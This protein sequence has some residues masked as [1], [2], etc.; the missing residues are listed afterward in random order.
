MTKRRVIGIV[1]AAFFSFAASSIWYSPMLFGKQ[2]IALSGADT[3][4]APAGLKIAAEVLRNLLLAFVI[5]GLL[6]RRRTVK[7]SELLGFAAML[8]LGFPLTLLSGSVLWQ[9]V[10]IQLAL[11][12]AGDWL[13]KILLMTLI[14]WLVR[15]RAL[16]QRF[17]AFPMVQ[18]N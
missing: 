16:D 11:I 5:S 17:A 6:T 2:F 3:N 8:W 15:R 18:A 7:L 10:P 14:P 12:H 9:N 1:L 4:A 13:I